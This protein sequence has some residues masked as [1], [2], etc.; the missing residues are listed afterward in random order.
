MEAVFNPLWRSKVKYDWVCQASKTQMLKGYIPRPYIMYIAKIFK[1]NPLAFYLYTRSW[2]PKDFPIQASNTAPHY[3]L[4]RYLMEIIWMNPDCSAWGSEAERNLLLEAGAEL[5]SLGANAKSLEF[6]GLRWLEHNEFKGILCK[7]RGWGLPVIISPDSQQLEANDHCVSVMFPRP[8][9]AP[10]RR[11]VCAFDRTYL[12]SSIQLL[13]TD[14]GSY[15][16]GGRVSH[17]IFPM[18]QNSPDPWT[19]RKSVQ[20]LIQLWTHAAVQ[21]ALIYIDIHCASLCIIVQHWD[22]QRMN[23]LNG[24]KLL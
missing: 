19:A 16:S 24:Y 17:R 11:L 1:K 4:V 22:I 15:M 9:D 7:L 12:E 8:A 13:S 20:T 2:P 18:W 5:A 14:Q 10:Q 3:V 6:F 23:I 21:N